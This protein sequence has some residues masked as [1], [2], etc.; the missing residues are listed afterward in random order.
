M[1]ALSRRLGGIPRQGKGALVLRMCG[2]FWLATRSTARLRSGACPTR[3]PPTTTTT[4]TTTT[5]RPPAASQNLRRQR[6]PHSCKHVAR[7]P[8]PKFGVISVLA[9]DYCNGPSRSGPSSRTCTPSSR[10]RRPSRPQ[11]RACRPCWTRNRC[12]S[13]LA[14]S[15]QQQLLEPPAPAR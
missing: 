10:P 15:F 11:T 3:P 14:I 1:L 7:S 9:V 8:M 13:A 4:T 6:L 5:T 2:R 12:K